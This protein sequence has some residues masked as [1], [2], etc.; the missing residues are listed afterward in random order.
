M[1]KLL[2]DNARCN[3]NIKKTD[4]VPVW[5]CGAWKND[6]LRRVCGKELWKNY[7]LWKQLSKCVRF[8]IN[9][10]HF[11]KLL[12]VKKVHHHYFWCRP[13]THFKK[14]TRN[15]S[16][17]FNVISLS[18]TESIVESFIFV[19]QCSGIVKYFIIRGDVLSWVNGL[20]LYDAIHL[21]PC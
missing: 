12:R 19:S 10:T 8:W 6:S 9:S 7:T 15:C 17:F 20:L 11:E 4:L 1:K 5:I 16:Y 21:L 18:E 13:V 2:V 3:H 14:Y